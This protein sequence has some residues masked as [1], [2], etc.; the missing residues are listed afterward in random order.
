MG[1][2]AAY[3]YTS[4]GWWIKLNTF[5]H[6]F[7][8]E[9]LVYTQSN[10]CCSDLCCFPVWAFFFLSLIPTTRRNYD[11]GLLQVWVKGVDWAFIDLWIYERVVENFIW[12]CEGWP[13][14]SVEMAVDKLIRFTQTGIFLE[15]LNDFMSSPR[16]SSTSWPAQDEIRPT[17]LCS[18]LL[19]SLF[20]LW[21][22]DFLLKLSLEAWRQFNDAIFYPKVSLHS[23]AGEALECLENY[24]GKNI[25]NDVANSF[26]Q[27]PSL[28]CKFLKIWRLH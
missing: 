21:F 8:A 6:N 10:S 1:I 16:P 12:K 26:G 28:K 22:I 13:G 14:W 19:T 25:L 27:K 18:C 5:C 17:S 24:L 2:S 7:R 23:V 20:P 9:L 4:T 3:T 11:R 15:F